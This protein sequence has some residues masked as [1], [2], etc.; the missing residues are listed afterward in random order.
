[1]SSDFG[2][3]TR[4]FSFDHPFWVP[5]ATNVPLGLTARPALMVNAQRPDRRRSFNAAPMVE[6]A[7]ATPFNAQ[8]KGAT[9]C[10]R[11]LRQWS[12]MPGLCRKGHWMP[13]ACNARP[14]EAA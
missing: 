2:L 4:C 11:A 8:I 10:S 14:G 3:S 12:G 7:P 9:V 5:A 1:M 13:V 6:P